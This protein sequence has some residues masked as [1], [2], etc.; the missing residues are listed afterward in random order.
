MRQLGILIT[1]CLQRFN[2]GWRHRVTFII[3]GM[4]FLSRGEK[5]MSDSSEK[6]TGQICPQIFTELK[7]RGDFERLPLRLLFS[8]FSR[9]LNY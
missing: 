5:I 2:F 7:G 4:G 3:P 1:A 6:L 9:E 8:V